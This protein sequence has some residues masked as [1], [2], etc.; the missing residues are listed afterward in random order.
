MSGFSGIT[1]YLNR[2][3]SSNNDND[4]N[5]SSLVN[6]TNILDTDNIRYKNSFNGKTNYLVTDNEEHSLKDIFFHK[7][8]TSKA[9]AKVFVNFSFLYISSYAYKERITINIYRHNDNNNRDTLIQRDPDLGSQNLT[10]GLIGKYSSSFIDELSNTS[11][12]TY[13]ITFK[14]ENNIS[15][16]P[17]GIYNFNSI[18]LIEY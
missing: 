18:I 17:Q 14:L 11:I 10:G 9:N 6:I 2:I 15:Q 1:N 12:Y 3:N 4:N 16:E 8:T 5:S 7:I 13:Y